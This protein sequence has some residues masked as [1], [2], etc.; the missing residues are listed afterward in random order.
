M[1]RT[2]GGQRIVSALTGVDR[3]FQATSGRR[4]R[5]ADFVALSPLSRGC[6]LLARGVAWWETLTF[7]TARCCDLHH[8]LIGASSGYLRSRNNHT[9]V[10]VRICRIGI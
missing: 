6:S 3:A 10:G 5:S 7:I 8:E 2:A 9:V 1:P 4:A